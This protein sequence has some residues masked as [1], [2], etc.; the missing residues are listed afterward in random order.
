M[1]RC[2]ECGKVNTH[3]VYCSQ[4]ISIELVDSNDLCLT[5]Q[6]PWEEHSHHGRKICC[7][8]E[9]NA[10]GYLMPICNCKA[11]KGI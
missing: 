4:Y 3:N 9:I 2:S 10:L 1:S 11:Y 8:A 7:A 5:C 6:H